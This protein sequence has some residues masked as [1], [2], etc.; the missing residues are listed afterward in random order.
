MDVKNE[1]QKSFKIIGISD[2][3]TR[4]IICN[5][6][7]KINFKLILNENTVYASII[8]NLQNNLN[9]DAFSAKF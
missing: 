2:S 6:T 8:E 5:Q 4:T 3:G 1:Y 7:F 9:V